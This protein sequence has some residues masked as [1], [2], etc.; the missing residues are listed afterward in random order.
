MCCKKERIPPNLGYVCGKE[1]NG[2]IQKYGKWECSRSVLGTGDREVCP[3]QQ[4]FKNMVNGEEGK[5]TEDF[6]CNTKRRLNLNLL[7]KL[8]GCGR[9]FIF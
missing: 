8:L 5:V 6:N 2:D 4:V 3:G 7:L 9:V 1:L